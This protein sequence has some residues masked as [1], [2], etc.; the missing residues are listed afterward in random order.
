MQE[1]WTEP[2]SFTELGRKQRF[3]RGVKTRHTRT[4]ARRL[5]SGRGEQPN[6]L[7]QFS[8]SGADDRRGSVETLGGFAGGKRQAWL[9]LFGLAIVAEGVTSAGE[10][11][12]LTVDEAL[13]L[14]GS[15]NIAAAIEALAG[16]TLVWLELRKLGFPKAQHIGFDFA[17][18][19]NVANLEVEAI[20]DGGRVD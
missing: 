8:T 17:D 19:S 2:E 13:D 7:S 4:P 16:A 3:G 9:R 15:L 12:A 18:A 11:V 14:E 1:R 10:G 20:G 6:D 5:R